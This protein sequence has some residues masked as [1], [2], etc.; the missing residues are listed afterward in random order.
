MPK[1]FS[2]IVNNFF[3]LQVKIIVL[4]VQRYDFFLIR[5]YFVCYI[6]W[7]M[8]ILFCGI[9]YYFQKG[10]P[11]QSHLYLPLLA[12][13]GV[14]LLIAGAEGLFVGVGG[15]AVFEADV[16]VGGDVVPQQEV[17]AVAFVLVEGAAVIVD[18]V[19]LG[20]VHA[21]LIVVHIEEGNPRRHCEGYR[22]RAV[23]HIL[24][25]KKPSVGL[26]HVAMIMGIPHTRYKPP[27][28][29]FVLYVGQHLVPVGLL[30]QVMTIHYCGRRDV[31]SPLLVSV[32]HIDGKPFHIA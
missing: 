24:V 13:V 15:D 17:E 32:A 29:S 25:E 21:C 1:K 9:E 27:R 18:K 30:Q 20:G 5:Q 11:L 16:P 2:I 4:M 10:L 14:Y 6:N 7:I 8:S 23:L 12:V 28:A 19:A 26:G 22:L 31:P 3:F